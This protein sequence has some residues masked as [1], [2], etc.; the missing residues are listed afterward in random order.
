MILII[1]WKVKSSIGDALAF[2]AV[3]AFGPKGIKVR[4]KNV[5]RKD[6]TGEFAG[7]ADLQDKPIP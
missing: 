5:V 4:E 1:R 7:S 6:K 2:G 3:R